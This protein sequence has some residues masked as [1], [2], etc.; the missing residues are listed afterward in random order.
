MPFYS[1]GTL[2]NGLRETGNYRAK[3]AGNRPFWAPG[4]GFPEA[5]FTPP[6]GTEGPFWTPG[7]P[8]P[9]I[10]NLIDG[11]PRKMAIFQRS[12]QESLRKNR[13]KMAKIGVLL[14][15]FVG[16][17]APKNP[18]PQRN[19]RKNA[20]FRKIPTKILRRG[21]FSGHFPYDFPEENSNFCGKSAKL[22]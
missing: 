4:N 9:G 2:K 18:S 14:C 8:D 6:D 16:N 5:N 10:S 11:A 13:E 1:G 15:F 3:F 22:S 20:K 12:L 7:T 21:I 19:R 17:F